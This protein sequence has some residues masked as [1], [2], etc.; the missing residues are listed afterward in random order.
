MKHYKS[1]NNMSLNIL[2]I[3][4]SGPIGAGE[5]IRSLTIAQEIKAESKAVRIKF[6]INKHA[7]YVDEIPF[8]VTLIDGTPTLNIDSIKQ[9]VSKEKPDVCIFDSGG[10]TSLFKHLKRLHIPVIYVSSRNST[11][12]KAF[13]W[14]WLKLITQHWIVQPKFANGPLSGMEKLKLR[15]T[16]AP[17]PVFLETV[18]PESVA[19]RRKSYKQQIGVGDE[20]FI[21]FSSGGGGKRGE[22][23]Q[24]P[25]IFAAAAS[26]VSDKTG[27]CCVVLMGPNYPGKAPEIPGVITLVSVTNY[28]F[29]DLLYDADLVVVGGGSSLAQCLAERK[30]IVTAPAAADQAERIDAAKS[31]GVV[32]AVDT[33]EQILAGAVIRIYYDKGK[34]GSLMSLVSEL[35][36]NNG[37]TQVA[38]LITEIKGNSPRCRRG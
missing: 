21:L 12:K 9:I 13:R 20:Q 33:D 36:L 25:D 22:G 4:V 2:F 8:P 30:L 23:A 37:L 24:A 1:E 29:I 7:K 6:V 26:I 14:R 27:V 32:M 19:S 11:R 16:G 31:I 5:Y 17:K 35:D 38:K 34:Q 10:R 15:L 3:P 18:F 28:H